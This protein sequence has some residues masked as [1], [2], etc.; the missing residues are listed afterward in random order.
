MGSEAYIAVAS[1]I[2]LLLLW[3]IALFPTFIWLCKRFFEYR[4]A[5]VL[6]PI[7][8]FTALFSISILKMGW[9]EFIKLFGFGYI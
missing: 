3:L 1:G 4:K 8:G 6:I 9:G 5:F 7:I 2:L